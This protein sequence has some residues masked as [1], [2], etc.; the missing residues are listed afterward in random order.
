[1]KKSENIFTQ[2]SKELFTKWAIAD[3]CRSSLSKVIAFLKKGLLKEPPCI[4]AVLGVKLR[5]YD[6]IRLLID[7]VD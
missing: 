2:I 5:C 6:E 4:E 7:Y 1:M 3:A